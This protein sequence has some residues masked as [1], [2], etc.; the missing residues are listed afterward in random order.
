MSPFLAPYFSPVRRGSRRAAAHIAT[1]LA[2]PL[3][4]AAVL[5]GFASCGAPTEVR[6]TV[7]LGEEFTLR[8][9]EVVVVR[10]GPTIIRFKGVREDSRCPVG[11]LILC[12]WEGNAR[13]EFT[14]TSAA[15]DESSFDLN[16]A[17]D[18]KS[19]DLGSVRISLVELSPE[20]RTDPA[21]EQKEYRARLVIT[22]KP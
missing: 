8:L 19:A 18:P 17:L 22:D 11:S 4:F 6:R 3:V 9:G 5:V 10:D 15:A 13:L 1:I 12:V 21:I 16:T 7:E 20:A 2:G 14:G